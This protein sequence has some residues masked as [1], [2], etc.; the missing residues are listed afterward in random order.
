MSS[1]QF[2]T[3]KQTLFNLTHNNYTDDE[4]HYIIVNNLLDF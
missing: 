2:Y 3:I 4:I 1:Y